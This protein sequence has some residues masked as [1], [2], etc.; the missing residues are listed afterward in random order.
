MPARASVGFGD[1]GNIII[2]FMLFCDGN[3]GCWKKFGVRDR[4]GRT[5]SVKTLPVLEFVG[6]AA[7]AFLFVVVVVVVASDCF[8][9]LPVEVVVLAAADAAAAA[10][11]F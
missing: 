8:S 7:D 4:P 1:G 3:R 2:A 6:C 10:A 11:F 9:L 5:P